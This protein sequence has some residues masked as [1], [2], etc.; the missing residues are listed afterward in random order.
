MIAN[1]LYT[2]Y[3]KSRN[4]LGKNKSSISEKVEDN[5]N[6]IYNNIYEDTFE[7]IIENIQDNI[8]EEIHDDVYLAQYFLKENVSINKNHMNTGCI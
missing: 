1:K 8:Q 3:L 2:Y 4:I 7:D 6:D 5:F